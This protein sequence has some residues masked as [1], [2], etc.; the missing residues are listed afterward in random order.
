MTIHYLSR[1]VDS[2]FRREGI[3]R[4]VRKDGLL[5]ISLTSRADMIVLALLVR[6]YINKRVDVC[7]SPMLYHN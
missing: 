6:A 5:I 1:L 7:Q 4:D 3:P 2:D